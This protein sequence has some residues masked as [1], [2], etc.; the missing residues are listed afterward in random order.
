MNYKAHSLNDNLGNPF[1]VRHRFVSGNV[2]RQMLLVNA[3]KHSQIGTQPRAC[4]FTTIAM[5]FADAVSILISGPLSTP[6]ALSSRPDSRVL[7]LELLFNSCRTAPFICLEDGRTLRHTTLHYLKAGLGV[8]PL[9]HKVAPR[10]RRAP[11]HRED[12]RTSRLIGAVSF[13]LVGPSSGRIARVE[14]RVAFSPQR[15]DTTHRPRK[16]SPAASLKVSSG[17]DWLAPV[18]ESR[19]SVRAPLK[20]PARA[21][22]SAHLWRFHAGAKRFSRAAVASSRR[23]FRS[24]SSDSDHSFGSGR[25][26]AHQRA[27]RGDARRC[28]SADTSVRQDVDNAPA[29]QDRL[30]R[31]EVRQLGN[32]SYLEF[33]QTLHSGDT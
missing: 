6:V 13:A 24:E 25:R 27:W 20:A 19:A 1:R 28:R 14:V 32:Q 29:T 16:L 33:N 15:S 21:A 18:G 17:G 4:S 3:A 8:R 9:A 12:R 30:A 26:L 11:H 10:P 2:S 22:R 5:N 7:R 31:Q 23:P